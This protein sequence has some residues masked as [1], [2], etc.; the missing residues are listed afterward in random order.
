M[1]RN[2]TFLGRP[3]YLMGLAEFALGDPTAALGHVER[4]IEQAPGR[5]ADFAGLRAAILGTLGRVEEA[6]TAFDSFSQGFLNRPSRASS[7]RSDPFANPR[8]HTWRRVGLAWSVHSF[9]FA[10][11]AILDRLA[12][13]FRAAGAPA[14]IGGYLKLDSTSRLRG[15]EIEALLFGRA[16]AGTD[17][18]LAEHAWRQRRTAAGKVTHWGYPV[19]AGLP[20]SATATG[21]IENDLLCEAWPALTKTFE[22]C[23]AIFRVTEP[24]AR[25]RWG[26][27]VMVTDTG[28]HPFSVAE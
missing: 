4:A 12:A 14:G 27:Y 25:L 26:D 7:V 28:P 11:R 6:R 16:I 19:H 2:P 8:Y 20:D 10:E 18:W 23:V 3:F 15:A 17:F 21:R 22:I 9:P 5:K 13:G 24:D 1:R